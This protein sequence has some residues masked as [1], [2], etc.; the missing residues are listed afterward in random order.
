[1]QN[2]NTEHDLVSVN[3]PP[4]LITYFFNMFR[5]FFFPQM[6]LIYAFPS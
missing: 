3:P 1:M 2:P 6:F 4:V 5:Q